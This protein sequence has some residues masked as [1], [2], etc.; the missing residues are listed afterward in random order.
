MEKLELKTAHGDLVT[1]EVC[2]DDVVVVNVDDTEIVVAANINDKIQH[3]DDNLINLTVRVTQQTT[4]TLK[5][6][7]EN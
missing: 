4:H 7:Q 2:V 5:N 3:L 6:Y 1:V